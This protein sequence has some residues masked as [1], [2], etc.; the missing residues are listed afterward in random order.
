MRSV[1]RRD[2]EL[3]LLGRAANDGARAVEIPVPLLV[4]LLANREVGAKLVQ[5]PH[6]VLLDQLVQA[7]PG[8]DDVRMT[9]SRVT[10][11][12]RVSLPRSMNFLLA[13]KMIW[14]L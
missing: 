10:H 7:Q 4:E 6:P 13:E 14:C 8:V 3:L 1:E 11:I 5:D 9:D 12:F 2:G